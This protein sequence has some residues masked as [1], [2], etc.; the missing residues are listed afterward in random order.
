VERDRQ[1]KHARE[2]S[3]LVGFDWGTLSWNVGVRSQLEPTARM[4]ERLKQQRVARYLAR[5]TFPNDVGNY[6][7]KRTPK[8]AGKPLAPKER[9]ARLA[10]DYLAARMTYHNPPKKRQQHAA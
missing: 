2:S 4:L 1:Q 3:L 7:G 8:P 6:P 9:F 5:Q 10:A